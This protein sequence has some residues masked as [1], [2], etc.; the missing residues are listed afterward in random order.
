MNSRL[1]EVLLFGATGVVG[2][3]VDVS[4][5][6]LLE[7][8]LGVYIARIPAFLLAATTTWVVNRSVTFRTRQP[9]YSLLREYLH[10]LTIMLGGLALNYIV[11][12]IAVTLLPDEPYQ[13][14]LAVAIGSL[15]GMAVNY[16]LSRKHIYSNEDT[17]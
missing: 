4:M 12:A 5:T 1:K 10:Y 8:T 6:L 17:A 9:R 14:F 3:L 13:L 15:A 16:S 11:Y 7:P 2:Y